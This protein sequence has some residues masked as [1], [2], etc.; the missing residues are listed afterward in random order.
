MWS[1][2]TGSQW[3]KYD[4]S[5][6]LPLPSASSDLCFQRLSISIEGLYIKMHSKHHQL[7]FQIRLGSTTVLPPPLGAGKIIRGG[8]FGTC[9]CLDSLHGC[10]VMSRGSTFKLSCF[11]DG[12]Y[13]VNV[14]LF[15]NQK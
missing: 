15:L 3:L 10:S 8:T 11:D 5:L 12:V 14:N 6:A 1:K 13:M 9:A 2:S 4:L 7:M